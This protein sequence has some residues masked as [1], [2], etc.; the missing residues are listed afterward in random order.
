MIMNDKIDLKQELENFKEQV[1]EVNK[2]FTQF[3]LEF[4]QEKQKINKLRESFAVIIKL[5]NSELLHSLDKNK[6]TLEQVVT[7]LKK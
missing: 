4:T 1:K 6:F 5:I 3:E 2:S 7:L